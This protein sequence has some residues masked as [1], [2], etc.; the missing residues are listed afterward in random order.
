MDVFVTSKY[1]EDPIKNVGAR[2]FTTLNRH[3]L[4][5]R[6]RPGNS[7]VHGRI[8]LNFVLIQDLIVVLVT[9]KNEEDLIRNES[10]GVFTTSFPL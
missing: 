4:P 5:K 8:L 6:S 3:F 1:E 2:V 9:C 10:A 7:S